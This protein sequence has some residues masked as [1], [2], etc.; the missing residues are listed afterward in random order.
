[1]SLK[2]NSPDNH[3]NVENRGN[4]KKNAM[5]KEQDFAGLTQRLPFA[6]SDFYESYR[7]TFEN[8]ELGMI[9]TAAPTA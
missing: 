5:T 8:T 4:R 9:K 2:Q 6:E 7:R 1:M 3:R